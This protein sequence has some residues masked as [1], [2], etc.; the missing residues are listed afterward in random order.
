MSSSSRHASGNMS[1]TKVTVNTSISHIPSSNPAFS[2]STLESASSLT[3]SNS[4]S[5]QSSCNFSTASKTLTS[6]N[7]YPDYCQYPPI[8]HFSLCANVSNST[9]EVS[10]LKS[11]QSM[12]FE[13]NQP[14]ASFED[15]PS[16]CCTKYWYSRTTL[17]MDSSP[18]RPPQYHEQSLYNTR[19]TCNNAAN[20]KHCRVEQNQVDKSSLLLLAD[21]ATLTSATPQI[22]MQNNPFLNISEVP[23]SNLSVLINTTGTQLPSLCCARPAQMCETIQDPPAISSST[24]LMGAEDESMTSTLQLFSTGMPTKLPSGS[25]PGIN[26]QDSYSAEV[27]QKF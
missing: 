26:H 19:Y 27:I 16:S 1:L 9:T 13:G 6:P 22:G 23:E 3:I 18:T 17:P 20:F 8:T 14:L 7:K 2:T 12:C 5:V 10:H 11:H 15:D 21:C 4:S 24:S 25:T